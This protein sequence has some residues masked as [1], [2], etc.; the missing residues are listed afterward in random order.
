MRSDHRDTHPNDLV[1]FDRQRNRH[2]NREIVAA[3]TRGRGWGDGQGGGGGVGGQKNY[4]RNFEEIEK[5]K[6]EW[7]LG[8][9]HL[10]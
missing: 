3:I 2:A 6:A 4:D 5:Y 1:Q 7:K 9:S 8:Q 10:E